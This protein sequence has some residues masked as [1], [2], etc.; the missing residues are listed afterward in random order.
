M[1][2]PRDSAATRTAILEAAEEVFLERG[3]G[4]TALSEIARRAEVT[5]SLI[6]HHFGSKEGLWSEV[7]RRRFAE[8]AARQLEMLRGATASLDLL[9]DSFDFY[10]RFLEQNPQ[11]V[12]IMAWLFL[13][14]Q[15]DDT[16]LDMD[17]QLV[18]AGV[19]T[20]REAQE[21]GLIRKDLDA[22]FI[23][24][25]FIG[26]AQHWHQDRRHF[27]HDFDQ[28]GLPHDDLNTAFLDNALKILLEGV[29][30]R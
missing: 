3:F 24:F 21:K 22:R 10:F 11:I 26:M 12:R 14:P 28:T 18:A 27:L 5:K 2:R 15:V 1:R 25:I 13:E 9:R 17:R 16:C 19:Q 4:Q 7:K 30:A 23:V 20:L 29:V 6:H 8:Y